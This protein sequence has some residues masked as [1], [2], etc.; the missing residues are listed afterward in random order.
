MER[1]SRIK[2]A[3]IK[4]LVTNRMYVAFVLGVIGGVVA[5]QGRI[6]PSILIVAVFWWAEY[7]LRK[8]PWTD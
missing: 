1:W 7:K 5:E 3:L 4:A 2:K 8:N 6:W